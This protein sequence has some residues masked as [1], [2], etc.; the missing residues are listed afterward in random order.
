MPILRLLLLLPTLLAAAP[1]WAQEPRQPVRL[2][3][4][5]EPDF[6]Q[7]EIIPL[8][9][10]SL[11]VYSRTSDLRLREPTRAITKYNAQ[12]EQ[13]WSSGLALKTDF[14]F[15]RHY[16]EA[17]YTYLIFQGSRTEH[18]TFVRLHN[19]TGQLTQSDVV[20]NKVEYIHEFNVL[21]GKHFIISSNS[22]D[23]KPTLFYLDPETPKPVMLPSLYGSESTFSDLLANAAHQRLD[24]VIS[25]SN[26][27]I[28]RLQ[29]KSFDQTGK[30]INNLFILQQDTRSL[31]QAEITPGD[32]LSRMLLGTYGARDLRYSQGFFTAPVV[33]QVVSGE[34]YSFLDLQNFFKY[35]KPRR[36]ERTRKREFARAAEGKEP[37][38]RYRLLLHD[39]I[40]TPYGYVLA[41]EAYF[42]QYRSNSSYFDQRLR[43]A[44]RAVQSYK[45][46]HAVAL[47][48]DTDGTLLWDNS[49]PLRDVLT[50][51]LTYAMEVASL[52][53]N[54]VVMAYPEGSKVYYRIMQQDKF[55]EEDTFIEL[56][57]YEEEEKI[58]STDR[59]GLLHWY[60]PHFLSFGQ[61]R[62]R[63]PKGPNRSVY[64]INKISF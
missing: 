24:V 7:F 33:S 4:T 60:G 13:V 59:V 35:M 63:N 48:F 3:L 42:P 43:G 62:I 21:R 54:R 14:H 46:T 22:Y 52:P 9:D 10:S 36:E 23:P 20:L 8:P 25:E 19:G 34:F 18:Y 16:T 2:E 55:T 50:T 12:L 1:L 28:S 56:L 47:G 39:L 61:Q 45:R 51:E 5:Q 15:V 40:V 38:N 57:S 44:N 27:R 41:A 64:Y 17:P 6:S 58:I 53:D 30:L 37:I 31:L 32:T 49:Y 29:V 26:G 11:L